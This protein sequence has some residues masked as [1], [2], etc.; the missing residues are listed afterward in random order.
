MGKALNIKGSIAHENLILDV[1][2]HVEAAIDR[3]TE[4]LSKIY[5]VLESSRCAA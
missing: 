3:Q 2:K 5:D 1:V 4:V